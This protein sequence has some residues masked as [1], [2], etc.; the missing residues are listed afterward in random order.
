MSK[1]IWIIN[2]YAGSP[3][4]GMGLRHYYIARELQKRG[5]TP[6]ILTA[7]F[8]HLLR[9]YE[10]FNTPYKINNINNVKYLWIRVPKYRGG[11]DK[12]RVL[13]W[14]MFSY[15]L[16][17]VSN[18][19]KQG[20]LEKPNIIIASTPEIFH[21]IPAYKLSKKFSSKFIYEVRDIWP[22]SL[23]E[24]SGISTSHPLIYLMDKIEKFMYKKADCIVSVL[25]NFKQY[26]EDYN[27]KVRNLKIIPNGICLDEYK[28]IESLPE[29][30]RK[31][32]PRDKFLVVYTGTFGK[33]NA[34]E[35]L[36]KAA[37]RLENFKKIHFLLVGKGEEESNL[38]L[39]AKGLRNITFLPS[40]SKRQVQS[41]LKFADVCYI[42]L[43]NMNIFR[44][45]VSPNKIF[46]YMYAA[47]PI[48]YAVNSNNSIVSLAKCGIIIEPE[49]PDAIKNGILQLFKMSGQER[50]EM[51]KRGREYVLKHHTY[52]K[53]VDKWEEVFNDF[54]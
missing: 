33:T 4:H 10:E 49:N 50:L 3:Y 30:I 11:G 25:P 16:F 6:I 40:V 47:K 43:K 23:V 17:F 31:G 15:R 42:G 51:G 8:S 22:L 18:L 20:I 28:N 44:Y 19:V 53:L 38:K 54:I 13:K 26:L 41:I 45:G 9:K 27:I 46:D 24:L 14:L 1:V 35:Y 2:E 39:L 36:I 52:E 12:K 29:D 32:I 21:L 48:I 5:Y 37:K 7:S 34:L